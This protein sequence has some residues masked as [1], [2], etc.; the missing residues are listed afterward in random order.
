[1]KITRKIPKIDLPTFRLQLSCGEIVFRPFTVKEERL[2]LMAMESKDNETIIDTIA[3]VV[4]N[5]VLTEGFDLTK[6][7]LFEFEYLFLN[8][9]AR[10]VGE[11]VSLAY[12]CKGKKSDGN[13]CNHEFSANIDLIRA[14]IDMKEHATN[15]NPVIKLSDNLSAKF[16]YPTIDTS[17]SLVEVSKKD[18]STADTE[19][20]KQCIE[21]L[22]DDEQVY[23]VDEMQDGEFEQIIDSLTPMKRDEVENFFDNLP[24]LSFETKITCEACGTEHRIKL[25]GLLDFF[26]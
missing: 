22:F 15:T 5:C 9:R 16:R 1:M 21:Y 13:I 6:L 12:K 2:F 17:K 10:S 14:G 11:T 25:E 19:T 3:Q 7:P 26:G 23:Q 8:I 4:S 20:I 18:A 24:T